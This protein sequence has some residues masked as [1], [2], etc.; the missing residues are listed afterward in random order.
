MP[1]WTLKFT[2][3]SLLA[4]LAGAPAFADWAGTSGLLSLRSDSFLSDD[5]GATNQRNYQFIGA[6]VRTTGLGPDNRLENLD[7]GLQAEID[8]QFAPQ[9]TLMSSLNIRQLYNQSGSISIGRKLENWSLLDERW[10]FGMYQPQYRW[11]VLDPQSQGLTGVFVHLRGKIGNAKNATPWGV[12]MFGTPLFVPDQG[13]SYELKDGKF[14]AANPW[15]RSPPTKARFVTT[16]AVD[17]IKYQINTPET[18][19][20][21]FNP[22]YA[23]QAYVGKPNDGGFAQVA[24]AYKPMNVLSLPAR[25]QATSNNVIQI[26]IAPTFQY[27]RLL[28]ADLQYVYQGL[29]A[30]VG[31]LHEK[32]EDPKVEQNWTYRTFN[33]STLVSPFIGARLG[34][35]K[36][37]LM[38][39]SVNEKEDAV[40]GP[41]ADEVES[42]MPHRY[43]FQN[44]GAAELSTRF[45][46]AKSEGIAGKVRYTQGSKDEF[47]LLL[48]NLN[49]QMNADWMIWGQMALVRAKVDP[50]RR[51]QYADYEN[52]DFAQVGVQY[53]F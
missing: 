43:P 5:Y 28:S 42:A 23:A 49:F 50:D 45:F 13:A 52:N 9:A 39:L 37:R 44:A 29:E 53:V 3:T 38:T 1:K 8:G 27:H 31:A 48:G 51:I 32:P 6:G 41:S 22:G 40:K 25:A 19:R 17:E 11:N 15:F 46:W 20:V 16:G 47:S 33:E 18:S 35:F 26:E 14:E 30:G 21:V 7:S 12:M 34:W 2:I 36:L 10:H 24:F 4:I